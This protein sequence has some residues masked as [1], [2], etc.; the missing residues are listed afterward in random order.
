M[1]NRYFLVVFVLC[2]LCVQGVGATL[3]SDWSMQLY[4]TQ[5]TTTGDILILIRN[6]TPTGSTPLY[7]YVFYDEVCLIQKQAAPSSGGVYNYQLDLKV[8]P[9]ADSTHTAYGFHTIT[10]RIEDNL[11]V[12]YSRSLSYKIVD[13]VPQGEWWKS[14]PKGYYDYLKGAKGD[15]G[16]TGATGPQGI[17]GEKGDTGAKGATGDQ[18]PQGDQGSQG[19]KGDKGDTGATGQAADQTL[20]LFTFIL[21]TLSVG[22]WG[23]TTFIG[24]KK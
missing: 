4:P 1:R 9:P 20:T 8:K 22:A 6:V 18:G 2:C 14:L 13:G 19:P 12:N 3:V 24:R 7:V 16:T 23:Y 5:G 15:T 17:Q 11:G 10:I 21:S